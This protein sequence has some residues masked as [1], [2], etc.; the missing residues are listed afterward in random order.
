MT[1]LPRPAARPLSAFPPPP[2]HA[3]SAL[4]RVFLHLF[5][6]VD[7]GALRT[8]YPPSG[9]LDCDLDIR[10]NRSLASV[11]APHPVIL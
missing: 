7:L 10:S 9:L 1:A 8:A 3:P 5:L 4:H 2:E 11:S 6:T